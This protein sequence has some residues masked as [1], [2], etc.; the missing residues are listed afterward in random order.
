LLRAAEWLF[1]RHGY[2]GTSRA[3]I[4]RRAGV[5]LSSAYHHFPDKQDLL[6]E[7]IDRWAEQRSFAQRTRIDLERATSGDPRAATRQYL[8]R[9]FEDHQKGRSLQRVFVGEADRNARVRRR[10]AE[11]QRRVTGWVRDLLEIGM[12]R[13]LVVP[14]AST[15]SAAFLIQ[16]LIENALTDLSGRG[17][18]DAE[19]TLDELTE[20]I[21]SYVFGAQAGK[22]KRR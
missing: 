9:S 13:G 14:I 22:Q 19:T 2:A 18:P 3:D 20:L 1:V 7:L 10:Y 4:A 12:E 21:C 17:A 16:S 15:E 6:L 5:A 8:A 11:A